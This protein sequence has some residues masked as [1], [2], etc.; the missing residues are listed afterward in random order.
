M[1]TIPKRQLGKNKGGQ[2][3]GFTRD[4][5]RDSERDSERRESRFTAIQSIAGRIAPESRVIFESP[6]EAIRNPATIQLNRAESW[7]N[8]ASGPSES[9]CES[10]RE[11]GR[12]RAL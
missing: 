10:R 9:H 7:S 6:P 12:N 1:K 5:G 4:S 11:S 2:S 8:R 3:G